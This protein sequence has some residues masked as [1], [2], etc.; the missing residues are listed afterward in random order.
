MKIRYKTV[1]HYIILYFMLMLCQS[2]LYEVFIKKYDVVVFFAIIAMIIMAPKKKYQYPFYI[3]VLLLVS[4]LFVRITSGGLGITTWLTWTIK[5]LITAV[6]VFYNQEKFIER[7]C[8]IVSFFAGISIVMYVLWLVFP[9]ILKQILIQ[10]NSIFTYNVWTTA[11]QYTTYNYENFGLFFASFTENNSAILRNTGIYTEPGVYQMVLNSVIFILIFDI[12]ADQFTLSERKKMLFIN[13]VALLTTI[14]TSGYFGLAVIIIGLLF[15]RT[16]K[17]IKRYIGIAL[18]IFAVIVVVGVARRGTG[19]F[20]STMVLGKIFNTS[21]QF[22]INAGTGIYRTRT[23]HAAILAMFTH[24]LGMGAGRLQGLIQAGGE[25]NVAGAV[26]TMGAMI[27]IIPFSLVLLW[28]FK[29]IV[30]SP[31]TMIEKLII[32]FLY[33]NTAIAQSSP[34]YPPLIIFTL[35][36]SRRQVELKTNLG[37]EYNGE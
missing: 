23:V 21:G 1:F 6:A 15:A 20:L 28:I 27:G 35:Y 12:D 33:F 13:I 30:S 3:S 26:F 10:Y 4:I 9:G 24:P 18:A 36:Y 2:N 19:S 32:V 37:G 22:D 34:F 25:G 31:L 8:R 5:I 11:S 16:E 14:S 7:Y 17:K 29:P